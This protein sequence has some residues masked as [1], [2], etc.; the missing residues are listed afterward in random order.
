MER[1]ISRPTT[2]DLIELFAEA[3]HLDMELD[4]ISVPANSRL[5]GREVK[6]SKMKEEFGVLLVGI[7]NPAGEFQFNPDADHQICENDMLLVMGQVDEIQRLR[8]SLN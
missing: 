5:V 2:A 7:K 3:S 6:E 4:E 1:M 8:D